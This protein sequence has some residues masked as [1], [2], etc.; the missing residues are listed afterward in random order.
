MSEALLAPAF[1]FRF[2]ASCQYRAK[3]G[4]ERGAGLGP[5]FV[6]PSFGELEGRPMFADFR[7]AWSG[8]G[9]AFDLRVKGKKQPLW[10]RQSRLEDSDGLQV[11]ID[12]RDAHNIHRATRFCHHFI[13]LPAGSGNRF[14]EPTAAL[15]PIHRARENPRT[16]QPS[17]LRV[18]AQCSRGGYR[19]QARV[20][21]EALTGFEPAE[22]PR[23]GFS[24]AVVD[25]ELGWQTFSVGPEFPF[26]EDPSLWGTL[27]LVKK[28]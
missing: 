23:L 16:I 1:L 11:W 7:V 21:A 3:L 5:T 15:V 20:P 22:Q 17:P 18:A 10:C 27:E 12:T 28:Q 26:S 25:R 4:S 6:L 2:S 19:L 9:L 14:E 24:Y 8:K 13:F